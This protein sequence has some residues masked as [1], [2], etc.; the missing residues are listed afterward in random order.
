MSARSDPALIKANAAFFNGDRAE[1]RRYLREY[2]DSQGI[3]EIDAESAGV[4]PLVRWLDAQTQDDRAARLEKLRVLAA[5][6]DGDGQGYAPMAA[7]ALVTEARID[8]LHRPEKR[9]A[10]TTILIALA[11]VVVGASLGGTIALAI[12]RNAANPDG[13]AAGSPVAVTA[14]APADR[15]IELPS[16]TLYLAEYPAGVLRAVRIENN[17]LRAVDSA[18]QMLIPIVGARFAAIEMQFEC[19][20]G[21]CAE[22]PQARIDLLTGDGLTVPARADARIFNGRHWEPIARG[23]VTGAWLVY[24]IPL[25]A[26]LRALRVTPA[27]SLPDAPPLEIPLVR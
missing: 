23:R 11:L 3:D 7:A 25:D 26:S 12:N 27:G 5:Q 20:A 15:S 1:T 6:P 14:A 18:G 10:W 13:G 16:E 8:A 21:I 22:P 4:P 24:E 17:S 9:A 19:R 2:L